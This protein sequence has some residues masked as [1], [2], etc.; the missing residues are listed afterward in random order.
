MKYLLFT[1]KYCVACA[2]VKKFLEQKALKGELVDASEN[3]EAALKYGV[4][5]VPTVVF[6]DEEGNEFG[7]ANNVS[8]VRSILSD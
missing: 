8:D 2:P 3:E 1:T 5:S 4:R 6:F 7:R